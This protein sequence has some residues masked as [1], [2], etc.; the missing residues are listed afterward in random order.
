MTKSLA[1]L[2]ASSVVSVV[3]VLGAAVSAG[4]ADVVKGKLVACSKVGT[5]VGDVNS[6][7]KSVLPTSPLNSLH[8]TLT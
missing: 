5:S 4:A 1:L 7:G 2:A 3:L 6:C 8:S